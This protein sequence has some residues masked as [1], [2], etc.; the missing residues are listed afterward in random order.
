MESFSL[1]SV[2]KIVS[3]F[4]TIGL[5]IFLWWQDNRRIENILEKNSKDMAAVLDRYSKDMAEQR[6]MYES[7][8]SLCKDFASVTND[9]RDI[10]TLNIQTMTECKDS[11][12]QNQFCPVIRISKKK[13][14]RLVMD[15]ES[16]GG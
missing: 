14:M 16:V 13:A 15:E 7:N 2:L 1:G 3:D 4:G 10:V 6:K 8:V 11:I 12:N 5:I 9:L